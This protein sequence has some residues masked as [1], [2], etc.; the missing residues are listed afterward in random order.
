MEIPE[1]Y[2]LTRLKHTKANFEPIGV[3]RIGSYESA[4]H[5]HKF[6]A[7]KYWAIGYFDNRERKGNLGLPVRLGLREMKNSPHFKSQKETI[8]W[9]LDNKLPLSIFFQK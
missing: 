7:R 6:R 1:A 9:I 5:R 2:S 3:G 4:V 8:Q